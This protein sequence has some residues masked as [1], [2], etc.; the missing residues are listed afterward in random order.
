MRSRDKQRQSGI[1]LPIS[2]LPDEYGIG[3][4]GDSA[5]RFADFLH[6]AGQRLWQILP[7]V[8]LGEGDSP[9]KSVSCF[10]GEI[11]YISISELLREGLLREEELPEESAFYTKTDYAAARRL[12]LPLL[13]L[14]AA[15]F[16]TQS[17]AFK[18][19]CRDNAFW[20]EDFALFCA[21]AE[22]THGGTLKAF[23]PALKYRLPE[24]LEAFANANGA[25]LRFYR[26]TQYLFYKQ[27]FELKSHLARRGIRLIGD[28]PFYVS[29][30]SA[31]V[32]V[33]PDAFKVGRDFT[34]VSVAGVPPDCFSK[35]GQLWGN[36][37][38]NWEHHKRNGYAWWKRRLLF[39]KGLYDVLRIDHFRAFANYYSIPYGAPNAKSGVW[40]KGVGLLFWQSVLR[41]IGPLDIIAED[42][43]GEEAAVRRLISD[44]GFPDMRVV[45]FGFDSDMLDRDLPKNYPKNSVCY[46]GTHDNNTARGWY[47]SA[48]VKEK[49]FT[50]R[51]LPEIGGMPISQRMIAA[52]MESKARLA[53]IP[54]QDWLNLPEEGRMNTPGT[55]AGNWQWRMPADALNERL[56]ERIRRLSRGRN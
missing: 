37:I 20:L 49:L 9:Y 8:P 23:P 31:E 16:N 1:L 30:D 52:A 55:S 6:A 3:S 13:E 42:L 10:A 27:L 22:K 17:P 48:P 54:M 35:T 29:A 51:Y 32:W 46:T 26:V 44:T 19:F 34:P 41:D 4:L 11:L 2:C 47:E 25:R 56:C 36:P 45:Q 14:A 21:I 50:S 15:R 18:R 53:I 5:L 24:A 43:G 39:C 33:C 7:L 12:K 38:Y 28:I 40:E